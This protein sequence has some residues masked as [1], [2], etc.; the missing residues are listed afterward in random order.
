MF[1]SE[2]CNLQLIDQCGWSYIAVQDFKKISNTAM[3][4]DKNIWKEKLCRLA[5]NK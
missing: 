3:T 4:L 5:L 2:M 1:H